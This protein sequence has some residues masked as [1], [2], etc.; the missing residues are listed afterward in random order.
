MCQNV[1]LLVCASSLS[2]LP[3]G[4]LSLLIVETAEITDYYIITTF[5]TLT[6]VSRAPY[7]R[8][9]CPS[10]CDV[11]NHVPR[12]SSKF[13]SLKANRLTLKDMRCGEVL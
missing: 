4:I 7:D 8:Q 1:W 3:L 6:M 11:S 12:F 5:G 2:M 9:L 13:S 10:D